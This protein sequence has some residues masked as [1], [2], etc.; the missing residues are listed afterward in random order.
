MKTIKSALFLFLLFGLIT[1]CSDD[2]DT[3]SIEEETEVISRVVL[4][5][6]PTQGGDAVTA[7]WFDEDGEGVGDPT[8]DKIELEEDIEYMLSVILT[9][10]LVDP[11]ENVTA[12]IAMEDDEHMFFFAFTENLFSTPTGNGNVDNRDDAIIYNDQDE[13]GFPLGLST[14]WTAG[15]HTESTGE[16]RVVLKH[17]PNIKSAT[18]TATDGESDIDITFPI[19]IVEDPNEE[20]E[21][22]NEVI[23][24]FTPAEGGDPITARWLDADGEGVNN[25]TIDAISL[26]AN[27]EYQMSIALTNTLE[28][29][30]EDKTE[31]IA[32]EDDEHM[33]FFEFTSDIFT[34]PSGD[35][36]VDNRDDPVNY[37][38]QDE[39]G[40][41]VG[42]LTTWTTGSAITSS[43]NFQIILKH[44]PGG[45]KTETSDATTGGTDIN[46]VF[47]LN[48]Q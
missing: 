7:T 9:N 42:L 39:N 24:T 10:T 14:T 16:F 15:A 40:N 4:T 44:Q 21:I 34:N 22:I 33:F 28:E 11:D 19:D 38:D 29:P 1:S 45:L 17:Q 27:T 2:D 41:P 26:L 20:E 47:A 31:E 48:I 6:T 32:D 18:S 35:G 25:P 12:E 5:F 8:I 23:L 13:N 37:D 43:G 46:V 36:N 3:P 30:D